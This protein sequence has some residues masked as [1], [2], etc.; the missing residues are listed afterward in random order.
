MPRD[1]KR[2]TRA[3]HIKWCKQR[4]HQEY[5][6]YKKTGTAEEARLNAVASM[7]SDL[8]KHPDTLKMVALAASL[9]FTVKDEKSLFKFIDGFTEA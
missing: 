8:G 2:P 7:L 5:E 3:E 1:D 9:G 6:Y 4:A